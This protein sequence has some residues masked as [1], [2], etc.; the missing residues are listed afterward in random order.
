[1]FLPYL[2]CP[3]SIVPGADQGLNN[4]FSFLAAGIALIAVS[5]IILLAAREGISLDFLNFPR[6]VMLVLGSLALV[7]AGVWH[8]TEVYLGGALA[9]LSVTYFWSKDATSAVSC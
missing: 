6:G 7:F 4:A 9:F 5:L 8:T 1:L 3:D 2:Y